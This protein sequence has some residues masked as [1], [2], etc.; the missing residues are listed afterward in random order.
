MKGLLLVG[1]VICLVAS[2]FVLRIVLHAYTD[3]D[4]ID[5]FHLA[6]G[7]AAAVAGLLLLRRAYPSR[8]ASLP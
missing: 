2:I 5:V 1:A 4:H 7:I 8:P 6:V 3:H